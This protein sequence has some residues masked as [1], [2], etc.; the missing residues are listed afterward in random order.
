MPKKI[1]V[2][3]NSFAIVDD[4]D[5]EL[6]SQFDWREMRSGSFEHVYAAARIRM[7]RLIMDA[8]R[9]M[10][11]DHINGDTL[12]NRKCNLRL[13]TNAQ[14]QQNTKSRK[15]SSQF[16][17]VSFSK[18]KQRWIGTFMF[19]GVNYYCGGFLNERD[20]ARA[21]DKKRREVAGHFASK[22]LWDDSDG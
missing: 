16:K 15:G 18:R 10:M 9:G 20:C 19:E 2:G 22:N 4:E 6:V 3:K 1:P 14:N 7:H 5:F 12:D 13:A 17:G 11:V 8:P 21:V